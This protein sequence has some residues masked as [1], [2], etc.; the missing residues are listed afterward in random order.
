V[1]PR[2]VIKASPEDF[3][4]EEVPLYEPS[5]EGDHLYLRFTKRGLPTDAAVRSIARA[6]NVDARDVGV[7]G[8][9]D[10]VAITTQTISVPAPRGD[11]SFD[12]RAR[13]LAIDGVTI[14]DARRHGNK[15]RTGHLAAN[16]FTIV[17]RDVDP[18]RVDEAVAALERV[19]RD[20][21]ANFFG[22]Q[23]FGRAGDNA[24]RARAWLSG[25]EPGPR[26]P[27][28][29]RFLWSSLQ[30]A[31]F[32]DVLRRRVDD[33]TWLTPLEGDLLQKHESGG[34]FL[35]TDVQA[36]R[37]RAARGELSPTGPIP[38]AKMREPAGAPL[39]LESETI[40]S[41]LGESFDFARTKVLGEGTRRPLRVL[42]RDLHV[43]VLS[44]EQRSS[45]RVYFVLPK[46]AYATTILAAAFASS[47]GDEPHAD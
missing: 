43:S 16:K 37:E 47:D 12:E 18:A 28:A 26:D 6:L 32:N 31:V 14:H 38:G 46:G 9:K 36:D 34:L 41:W 30:S 4:V 1:L 17:V 22:E 44:G 19:G 42:V 15:L 27:R 24:E 3:V 29:R 23:R 7:A 11:A 35:C 5:G 40:R 13:T 21:A 8:L 39:A 25:K 20:G 2:G 45:V 10:K 33:G